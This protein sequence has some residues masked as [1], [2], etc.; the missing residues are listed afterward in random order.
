[1]LDSNWREHLDENELKDV[2]FSEMYATEFNHRTPGASQLTLIAK[3]S[4]LLDEATKENQ[5]DPD[6][7]ARSDYEAFIAS[8]RGKA[9]RFKS[10]PTFDQ[11]DEKT[12]NGWRVAAMATRGM[13]AR[14]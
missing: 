9:P 4:A 5:P 7:L 12:Q 8:I 11:L 2:Q 13:N 6:A 10:M 14:Y 1:M 3:L